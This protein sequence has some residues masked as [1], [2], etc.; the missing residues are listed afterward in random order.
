MTEATTFRPNPREAF[1]SGGD[2]GALMIQLFLSARRP[3]PDDG[4]KH[5]LNENV[6]EVGGQSVLKPPT[7][8]AVADEALQVALVGFQAKRQLAQAQAGMR[9]QVV[10]NEGGHTLSARVGFV[11]VLVREPQF[12]D[13]H[14]AL[15]RMERL[16]WE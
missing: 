1:G 6:S 9:P 8:G 10:V 3:I 5:G 2:V 16:T 13:P 7:A 15:R 14:V 11:A 4:A 12:E